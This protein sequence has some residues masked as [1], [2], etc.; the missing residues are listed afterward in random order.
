MDRDLEKQTIA[1][2]HEVVW[3]VSPALF[4]ALL[5]AVP[6]VAI[7]VVPVTQRGEVVLL[8]RPDNDPFF[9]GKVHTPG[10]IMRLGD[11]E[12]MALARAMREIGT[13]IETSIPVF[14]NRMHVPK[15]NGPMQCKRGQEIG[16]L[17]GVRL[18]GPIPS[19]LMIADPYNLPDNIL[20]YQRPMVAKVMEWWR[21]GH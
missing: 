11:T 14:I 18:F 7:E 5:G 15:G 3:P 10:S 9:A 2:L 17:F 19:N 20:D 1:G 13:N 4:D 21:K 12:E 6:T 8:P 16:L